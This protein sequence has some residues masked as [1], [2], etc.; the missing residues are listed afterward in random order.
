M[1][2]RRDA[3]VLRTAVVLGLTLFASYAYFYQA[4]GWNQNGRFA[5]VRA[6]LE[7]GT[8]RIDA[9][10]DSTGDRSLWEGHYYCD[11]APGASF[12]ALGPVA[13]ARLAAPS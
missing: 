8:L 12:L 11:K 3:S 6:L 7:Q 1:T 10:A 2:M 9:Y 4:G 5:L 13:A